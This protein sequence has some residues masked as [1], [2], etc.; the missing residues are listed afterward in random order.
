M[1]KKFAFDKKTKRM[2]LK[3]SESMKDMSR[4]LIGVLGKMV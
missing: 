1:I 3:F 2:F 4:R